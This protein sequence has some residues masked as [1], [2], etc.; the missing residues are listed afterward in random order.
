MLPAAAFS[1]SR[2]V[3]KSR[4]R[5]FYS[6]APHAGSCARLSAAAVPVAPDVEKSEPR[7]PAPAPSPEEA[8]LALLAIAACQWGTGPTRPATRMR[9]WSGPHYAAAV[10]VCA[11]P[12]GSLKVKFQSALSFPSPAPDRAG[13]WLGPARCLGGAIDRGPLKLTE[14]P[15][16]PMRS[17]Q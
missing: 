2:G 5:G 12:C 4:T 3:R 13:A 7:A 9:A 8:A 17:H 14:E 11:G 10:T 6:T 16:P 1:L 15:R